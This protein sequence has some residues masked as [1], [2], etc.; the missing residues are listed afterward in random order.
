MAAGEIRIRLEDIPL[1]GMAEGK[2]GDEAVLFLREGD[3]R[4]AF[5]AKCPHYGAPLAKGVL[6]GGRAVAACS[7]GRNAEFTAFLH[8]LGEAR[9]PSPAELERGVDLTGLL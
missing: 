8:L 3:G 6:Y 2:A 5:Q 4:R 1:G 9:L 7:I